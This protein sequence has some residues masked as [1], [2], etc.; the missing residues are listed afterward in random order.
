MLLSTA[1]HQPTPV[2]AA[3]TDRLLSQPCSPAMQTPAMEG[4]HQQRPA[5]QLL[6]CPNPWPGGSEPQNSL[7]FALVEPNHKK[8]PACF[9]FLWHSLP[10]GPVVTCPISHIPL[11]VN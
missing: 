7:L 10:V 6:Q 2:M 11:W 3:V 9:V 8:D 5:Q 1:F 4:L